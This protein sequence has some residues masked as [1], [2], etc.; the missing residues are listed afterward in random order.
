MTIR[1]IEH[2]AR[3]IGQRCPELKRVVP[4]VAALALSAI[5]AGVLYVAHRGGMNSIPGMRVP[6]DVPPPLPSE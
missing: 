2:S 3:V 1:S 6:S 4:V 5:V